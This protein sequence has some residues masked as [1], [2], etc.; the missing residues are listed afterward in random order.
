VAKPT[1]SD[2]REDRIDGAVSRET[3]RLPPGLSVRGA[4]I[5]ALVALGAWAL[6]TAAAPWLAPRISSLADVIEAALGVELVP[7]EVR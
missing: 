4:R 7:Q 6:A 2:A 1:P 5:T 3:E